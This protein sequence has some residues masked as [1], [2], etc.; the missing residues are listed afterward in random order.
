MTSEP[1][2]SGSL[3]MTACRAGTALCA[4]ALSVSRP[5]MQP[6]ALALE[7][8]PEGRH[9]Q[10]RGRCVVHHALQPVDAGGGEQR[11][12]DDAAGEHE[13]VAAE[14]TGR[15]DEGDDAAVR[16]HGDQQVELP[17]QLGREGTIETTD[18]CAGRYPRL[19]PKLQV[20][21][22][23]REGPEGGD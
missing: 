16:M 14:S 22:L 20:R 3:R 23:E 11:L 5:R 12:V 21:V 1:L 4:S 13:G 8:Q 18:P 17:G 6:D 19:L 15:V 9:P 10:A 2:R 7:V